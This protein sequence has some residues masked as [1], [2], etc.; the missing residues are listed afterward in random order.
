MSIISS[1]ANYGGKQ[2]NNTAYV[3]QFVSSFGNFATW[4]YTTS[5]SPNIKTI[6]PTDAM[7]DVLL[8][9]DL[10]VLGSINMASDDSVKEYIS[11]IDSSIS[12]KLIELQPKQ[13]SYA[14][15]PEETH[16]GFLEQDIETLFP[17]LV[18]DYQVKQGDTIIKVVNYI[19]LIPLLLLKIQNMQKDIEQLKKK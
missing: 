1:I 9:N 18:N 6:T 3:K 13:Y 11:N 15:T 19:E 5:S 17:D 2:P 10:I 4:L 14:S 12:D 16:Y 7:T 8:Q